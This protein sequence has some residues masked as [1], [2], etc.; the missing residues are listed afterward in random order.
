M[1]ATVLSVLLLALVANVSARPGPAVN[2][3][4][5]ANDIV[6]ALKEWS[7]D[8]L[9]VEPSTVNA[10]Q[11]SHHEHKDFKFTLLVKYIIRPSIQKEFIAAWLKVKE[12]AAAAKGNIR[13]NLSKPLTDNLLFYSYQEW[14]SKVDFF[15]W[16]TSDD[17]SEVKKLAKYIEEK[18]IPLTLTQLIP[19]AYHK[20]DHHGHGKVQFHDAPKSNSQPM[21]V[22]ADMMEDTA[23]AMQS[24]VMQP[25]DA[26]SHAVA[27]RDPR[28]PTI[29]GKFLVKPSE[30]FHFVEAAELIT[31]AVSEQEGSLVYGFSKTL[32]DDVTFYSY[33]VWEDEEALKKYFTSCAGKK[34]QE[35]L[36]SHDIVLT[37]TVLLPIES[38]DE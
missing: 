13:F 31:K 8:R 23:D 28:K 22:M 21:R 34:F 7:G 26:G 5:W 12:E 9:A 24:L 3:G 27:G 25:S 6:G 38:L 20:E 30:V 11:H 19:I 2:V 17:D 36:L 4:A 1:R 14:E 37:S 33:S 18:D 15:K 32:L 16:L 29:L 35:F 10:L